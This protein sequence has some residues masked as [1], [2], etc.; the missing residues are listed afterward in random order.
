[1]QTKQQLQQLLTGAGVQPNKQLGQHFLIDLNLMR[2]LIHEA[3]IEEQDTVLEVGCGTGS[4][5]E[6]LAERGARVIAAEL[7]RTLARIAADRL[8]NRP[9]VTIIQTDILHTKHVLC[10]RV[11]EAVNASLHSRPGRLLLVANLPYHVG[12]PVMLNLIS[13]PLVAHAMVVTV[14]KEVARRMLAGTGSRDYGALGIILGATGQTRMI[15]VL[16]PD[17]FWPKPAVDSAIVAYQRDPERIQAID[18]QAVLGAVVDL[19]MQHRRKMLKAAVRF[20]RAPLDPIRDWN[21]LFEHCR[22][23]PTWRPDRI[24]PDQYVHLANHITKILEQT[25]HRP[26]NSLE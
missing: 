18:S 14:Q 19:M 13:G 10:P 12:S 16:K 20:A 15:R 7:D 23:D 3:A 6:A 8:A 21:A 17:V 1:M 22:L 2:L 11:I 5:T 4:L 9:N 24:S 25:G 26:C